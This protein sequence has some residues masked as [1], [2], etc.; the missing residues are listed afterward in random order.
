M[1]VTLA[2]GTIPTQAT[3]TLTAAPPQQ[4]SSMPRN[5]AIIQRLL[6]GHPSR[7]AGEALVTSL[8][9][10]PEVAEVRLVNDLTSLTEMASA[11]HPSQILLAGTD[12]LD[13]ITLAQELSAL[14]TIKGVVVVAG[15]PSR[16][17]V[18]TALR[19]GKISLLSHQTSANRLVHTLLGAARGFASI[20]PSFAAAAD[21]EACPLTERERDVLVA[22]LRGHSLTE[23]AEEMFLAPGTIRNI[24]S[25]AIKKMGTRNRTAAARQAQA[26]GWL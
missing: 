3:P 22:T 15:N 5:T 24:S 12:G 25:N 9:L 10:L 8:Q 4:A 11:W 19:N 2:T 6:I 7:L 18:D 23:I 26:K 1:T 13:H 17:V 20:D 14:P 16:V 21:H